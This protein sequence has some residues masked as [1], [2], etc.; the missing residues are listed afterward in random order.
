MLKIKT[1]RV[2][3]DASSYELSLEDTINK[4]GYENILQ[5]MPIYCGGGEY[6][7]TIIYVEKV[8]D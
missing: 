7:Y 3:F 2:H 6:F 1:L 5:V 4:I 8:S